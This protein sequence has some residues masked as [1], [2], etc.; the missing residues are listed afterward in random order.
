MRHPN[1]GDHQSSDQSRVYGCQP[2]AKVLRDTTR[3]V[4]TIGSH[5]LKPQCGSV[6]CQTSCQEREPVVLHRGNLSCM[7]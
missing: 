3:G 5:M 6:R 7:Q 4:G 1:F 2:L